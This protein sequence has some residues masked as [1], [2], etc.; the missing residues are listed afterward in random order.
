MERGSTL[1]RRPDRGSPAPSHTHTRLGRWLP[2]GR[3]AGRVF[4]PIS[5]A[6]VPAHRTPPLWEPVTRRQ[7][8]SVPSSSQRRRSEVLLLLLAALSGSLLHSGQTRAQP[9]NALIEA[10]SSRSLRVNCDAGQTIGR[11]LQRAKPGDRLAV[12]GTCREKVIVSTDRV[13]LDGQGSAILD[14][15][16]G[17]P[18]EL[19]GL[20]TI[21]GAR[22]VTITGFTIQ[23]DLGRNSRPPLRDVSG[24]QH[25][26][27]G[28]CLYGH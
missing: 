4:W 13:T 8:L 18:T 21:D 5:G 11:A 15:G 25:Y 14:G 24:E 20:V 1:I 23:N 7:K 27:P 9:D 12:R 17:A 2:A 3:L 26:R 6:R 22:G 10:D 28:Q 16:G 19:T